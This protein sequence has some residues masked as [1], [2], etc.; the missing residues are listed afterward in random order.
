LTESRSAAPPGGNPTLPRFA[1]LG[2]YTTPDRNGHGQGINVYR[3]DPESGNLTSVQRIDGEENPSFFA[4]EPRQR[5]LY[6]VHGGEINQVSAF[7]IDRA[8]G[9]LTLLNR[10]SSHGANPVYL[11]VDAAS[12]WLVL[13]NFTGG[14]IAAYPL[15][16]DGRIGEATDV[17]A[18]TGPLGPHPDR[19]TMPHPHQITWDPASRFL[20]V[21]DRGEDRTYVYRLT[22]EGKFVAHDPGVIVSPPGSG[23]RHIAF[24]PRGGYAYLLHE[25]GSLITV[26]A[27]ESE[28]G[29]LQPLQMLSTLPS[30]FAGSSTAAE[31]VVAPSGKCV[32]ASN[33]GHDS[34]VILAMDPATGMLTPVDWVSTQGKTPRHFNL[35]PAGSFLYAENQDS[36][37]VVTFRVDPT[38]GRLTPTGH[39]VGAGSPACLVFGGG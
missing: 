26:F 35:D 9:R 10:Q 2:C 15:G 23:P 17:H 16:D 6:T 27:Y 29:M 20:F 37:T 34:I 11:A 33:R 32:Y 30:D 14:T 8:T 21:P 12:R 25:M 28:R 39:V 7:A 18:H 31:I 38:T 5:F 19:Q 36:A 3:A 1:Y 22:S 4:I 13:A 24:H